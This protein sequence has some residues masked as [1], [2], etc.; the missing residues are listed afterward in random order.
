V[1]WPIFLIRAAAIAP[2]IGAP[3]GKAQAKPRAGIGVVGAHTRTWPGKQMV[4]RGSQAVAITGSSRHNRNE[5]RNL[6]AD[7]GD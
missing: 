1:D 5:N 4:G 6:P 2:S 7:E 3:S